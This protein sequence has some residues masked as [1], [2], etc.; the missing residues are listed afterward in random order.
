MN[1]VNTYPNDVTALLVV[2]PYNDFIS[3]GGKVWDR[4]KRVADE[5]GC[6]AHMREVLDAARNAQ[7]RVCYVLHRRYRTG[8]YENWQYLAPVQKAAQSSKVF[9]LGTWGGEIRSEFAP[10]AG[11]VVALE[12]WC[13]SGFANTDLDLLLKRH[14]IQKVIVIGLIAHTCV[15]ATVRF[16]AELGYDV[17]M[18]KDATADYSDDEMRAAL[19]VNMPSYASAIV[20]AREVIASLP[21]RDA[22]CRNGE[23]SVHRD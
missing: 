18:V 14:G 20:T 17:T 8:D 2:D 15:E 21:P 9:E 4:L 16:A 23:R 11:D 1:L 13:S 22:V 12:H 6:V 5:N 3:E 10:Q 19:E 7:L